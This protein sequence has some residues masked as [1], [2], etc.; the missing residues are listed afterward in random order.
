MRWRQ[1]TATETQMRSETPTDKQ[2]RPNRQRS[3][4]KLETDS[5]THT[6]KETPIRQR[7]NARH[8]DTNSEIKD[9]AHK[10]H[11]HKR[12]KRDNSDGREQTGR[13]HENPHRR[14]KSSRRGCRARHEEQPEQPRINAQS[15][16]QQALSESATFSASGKRADN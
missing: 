16:R 7:P 13:K 8:T 12:F 9:A 6:T 15:T 2:T 3:A 10:Q 5:R 1:E 14:T 11:R 4:G